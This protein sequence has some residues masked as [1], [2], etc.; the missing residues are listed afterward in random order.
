ML[1]M[2]KYCWKITFVLSLLL[3]LLQLNKITSSQPLDTVLGL[4]TGLGLFIVSYIKKD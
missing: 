2:N 3:I 4:L 1:N